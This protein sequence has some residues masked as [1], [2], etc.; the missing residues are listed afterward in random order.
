LA[1]ILRVDTLESDSNLALKIATANVAF[2]DSNGLNVVGGNLTIG[3]TQFAEGGQIQTSGI[4]DDAITSDKILSVANTKISGL[5]QAAQIGSANASVINAGTLA[6]ARLPSGSVLQVVTSNPAPAVT[7][8]GTASWTEVNSD[9][10]ISI[11]PVN[12]SSTLL[13]C[14]TFLFGGNNSS[15]LSHFKIYDITNSADVNLHT[16]SGSRTPVHGGARQ[17][18]TDLNDI[19]VMTISTT[20]S[21][22][23]TNSRTYGLYSKNEGA[24]VTTKYFFGTGSDAVAIPVA[25]PLFVIY[26]IAP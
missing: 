24:N 14:C 23:S 1:G 8:L 5:I 9:F 11:T 15:I 10:R 3:A 17:V 12:A 19:D 7:S 25:R 22:G 4:A 20:V 13:I 18:D 26:E 16:G 2:I 21:A 6:K